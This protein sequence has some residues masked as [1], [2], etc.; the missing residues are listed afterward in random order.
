MNGMPCGMGLNALGVA[1]LVSVMQMPG[2]YK[3]A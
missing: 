3:K 2:A 1:S